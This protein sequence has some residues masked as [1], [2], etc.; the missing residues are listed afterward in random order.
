MPATKS[1]ELESV[2]AYAA[3]DSSQASQ[4]EIRHLKSSMTAFKGH[5]SSK[6]KQVTNMVT[7]VTKAANATPRNYPAAHRLSLT[8]QEEIK[9]LMQADMKHQL[10][11]NAYMSAGEGNA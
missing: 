3:M 2:A 4:A 9:V 1:G 7:Q 5:V 8:L 11:V 10:A 6:V